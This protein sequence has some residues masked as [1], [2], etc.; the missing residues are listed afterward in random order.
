MKIFKRIIIVLA[1]II[2]LLSIIGL[3]LPS[4]SHIERSIVINAPI[5]TVFE[6]VNVLKNWE[7][8]S[9]WQ[10]SDTTSKMVYNDVA[11]GV[12]ASYT[13]KGEKSGSGKLTLDSVVANQYIRTK[14][15]FDGQTDAASHFSFAKEGNGVK[16]TWLMDMDYGWNILARYFGVIMINGM[17]EKDFDA[18]LLGIKDVAE[19]APVKTETG[20]SYKV[21]VV[22][23][24]NIVALAISKKGTEQT[25]GKMLSDAY[26]EIMTYMA[27]NKI[28]QMGAPF[29]LIPVFNPGGAVELEAA[30]PVEK[31]VQ[32]SGSIKM[33]EVKSPH[34]L[35]VQYY[36]NYEGTGAAHDAIDKY[37]KA[38]NRKITGAPWEV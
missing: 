7:K 32:V 15:N 13:W 21:Q 6:Q 3:L 31:A 16:V 30:I 2:V 14:L 27:K 8:W 26:G 4:K 38:N 24:I 36:G 10:K 19:H 9:P 34:A 1:A 29:A 20:A 37:A 22:D 5:E 23:N 17:L 12:N 33:L 28:K 35:L 18:G 25:I 11:S